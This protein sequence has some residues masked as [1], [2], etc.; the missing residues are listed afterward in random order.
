MVRY[1]WIACK[2]RPSERK[3]DV[4]QCTEKGCDD[5]LLDDNVGR[6]TK[7]VCMG[8][9]NQR[10]RPSA[11]GIE[12]IEFGGITPTSVTTAV[13]LVGGVRSYKGLRISRLG[14]F[15]SISKSRGFVRGN[16]E[17]KSPIGAAKWWNGKNT[18]RGTTGLQ[19][20]LT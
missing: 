11:T 14:R 12:L 4:C 16:E 6:R 17:N 3:C 10:S 7:R 18:G 1:E 9:M 15:W 13:T 20:R 19:C 5:E 2:N 8:R